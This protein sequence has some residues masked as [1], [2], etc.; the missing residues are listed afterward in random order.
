MSCHDGGKLLDTEVSVEL[1]PNENLL[2]VAHLPFNMDDADFKAL[3]SEYGA[4]ERCFLMRT[5]DGE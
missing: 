1:Y 2:C 5:V 4:I 3:V